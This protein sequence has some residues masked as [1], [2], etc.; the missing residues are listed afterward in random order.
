MNTEIFAD[1]CFL[2]RDSEVSTNETRG[3]YKFL[4]LKE[5]FSPSIGCVLITGDPQRDRL[6]ICKWLKFGLKGGD[7]SV[8]LA[9]DAESA[10]SS[11]V[12]E[13]GGGF[14]FSVK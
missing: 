8:S 5:T 4:A 3:S 2:N 1:F 9:T 12:S 6:N 10:V 14:H 7:V 13:A 11:L